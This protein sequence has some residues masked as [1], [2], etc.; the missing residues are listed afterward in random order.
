[1]TS[2]HIPSRYLHIYLPFRIYRSMPRWN[3]LEEW[4]DPC[5]E[6]Y[7]HGGALILLVFVA[8]GN[9]F[10]C[11]HNNSSVRIFPRLVVLC[12]V[13]LLLNQYIVILYEC[14]NNWNRQSFVIK[15][16]FSFVTEKPCNSTHVAASVYS[17]THAHIFQR[18]FK[19]FSYCITCSNCWLQTSC[20]PLR[21]EMFF[22]LQQSEYA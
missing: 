6:P 9:S 10:F 14:H 19:I 15:Y 8:I 4:Q 5:I 22:C 17:N 7:V 16:C 13:S 1:M 11:C 20:L 21:S 2:A 18:L 3:T 12:T